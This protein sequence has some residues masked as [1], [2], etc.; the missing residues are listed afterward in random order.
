M[1]DRGSA[2]ADVTVRTP[3]PRPRR[4][5]GRATL[6]MGAAT[7]GLHMTLKHRLAA[8]NDGVP[9]WRAR[10]R[11]GTRIDSRQPVSFSV[12]APGAVQCFAEG[13][14]HPRRARSRPW[15]RPPTV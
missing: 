3:S 13:P 6:G 9:D 10:Q 4:P 15:L 2:C 11:A 8:A 14:H 1:W 12:R 5:P 7:V